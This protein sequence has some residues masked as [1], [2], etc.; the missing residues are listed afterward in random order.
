MTRLTSGDLSGLAGSLDLYDQQLKIITGCSLRQLS[1]A[2]L[3]VPEAEFIKEAEK[4]QVAAIPVTAGK[5]IISGFSLTVK[6]IANH[7][8]FPAFV[9]GSTDASGLYEA[10]SAGAGIVI[11]ADDDCYFALNLATKF[12]AENSAATAAGFVK[13]L[14]LMSNGLEGRTVLVIGCGDVGAY[15]AGKAASFGAA[16]AVYDLIEQHSGRLAV[17]I[18]ERDGITVKIERHLDDAFAKYDLIIDASP[19]PCFIGVEHVRESTIIVAP[20]VPQGVDSEARALLKTRYLHDPLQIGTAVMLA[21]ALF[22]K[23]TA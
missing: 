9:T 19:G 23:R 17:T 22:S 7:I 12:I 8:G 16:P 11:M 21:S 3:G 4:T 1:C 13:A 10:V 20:G 15:A 6:A 14:Q 18:K 2:A 5:G